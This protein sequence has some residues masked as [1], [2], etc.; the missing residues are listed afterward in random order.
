MEIQSCDSKL[1][2]PV[3]YVEIKPATKKQIEKYSGGFVWNIVSTPFYYVGKAMG[4]FSM[5][6]GGVSTL[7]WGRCWPQKW[8]DKGCWAFGLK[9]EEPFM[10]TLAS[11]LIADRH[12]VQG[13]AKV[14]KT[15]LEHHRNDDLFETSASMNPFFKIMQKIW[16]KEDFSSDDFMIT[17]NK[18]ATE[19]YRTIL[20]RRLK[21]S[22]LKEFS[23]EIY[24]EV[25]KSAKK[26]SENHGP[27]NICVEAR[28][29]TARIICRLM[30]GDSSYSQQVAECVDFFNDYLIKAIS[31]KNTRKDEIK[32]K[33][34]AFFF[35]AV[36]EEILKKENLPLFSEKESTIQHPLFDEMPR[37]ENKTP[38]S[39]NQK[40]ALIFTTFF[41]AQETTAALLSWTLRKLALSPELQDELH[42]E[43]GKIAE[44]KKLSII[45]KAERSH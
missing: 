26:W 18:E 12:T 29:F 20:L 23:A 45:G 2:D 32:F 15:I 10:H 41:A 34:M 25:K 22:N 14:I 11:F 19:L 40:R 5:I 39:T 30:C 1:Y 8:F 31:K 42:E 17:C 37:K 13:S 6:L 24:A 27:V 43:A 21:A 36:I 44:K 38:L 28:F 3:I 35:A 33:E 16:P 9:P 4:T 7:K